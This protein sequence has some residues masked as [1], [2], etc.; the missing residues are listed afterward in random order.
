MAVLF[1]LINIHKIIW[2]SLP[3]SPRLLTLLTRRNKELQ[4]TFSENLASHDPQKIQKALF[5]LL[6]TL[7]PDDVL[8][9]DREFEALKTEEKHGFYAQFEASTE[10]RPQRSPKLLERWTHFLW[11][12]LE[13]NY[14]VNQKA[15]LNHISP[16]K[17]SLNSVNQAIQQHAEQ[18][19]SIEDSIA[20]IRQMSLQIVGTEH[21]TDP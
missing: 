8:I 10:S 4:M 15:A 9:L 2:K 14:L 20:I 16:L 19:A 13:L 17:D 5:T 3:F 11:I 7:T 18:G 1:S 12:R 21:P 6:D